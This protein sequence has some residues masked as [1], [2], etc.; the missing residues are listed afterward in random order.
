MV[1]RGWPE[2][3]AATL[4]QRDP[5]PAARC[6]KASGGGRQKAQFLEKGKKKKPRTPHKC[7]RC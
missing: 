7:D 4:R 2:V 5:E 6:P 3:S 1:F